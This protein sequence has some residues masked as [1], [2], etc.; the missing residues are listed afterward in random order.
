MRLSQYLEARDESESAFARRSGVPQRT[1][2][3]ICMGSGCNVSTAL[4]IIRAT[5]AH[6]TPDDGT[7]SLEDLAASAAA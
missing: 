4:V 6:P 1:I 2:N 5:H 7:V 3:R